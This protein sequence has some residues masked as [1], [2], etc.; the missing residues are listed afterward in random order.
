MA[1]NPRRTENSKDDRGTNVDDIGIMT[2]IQSG[3]GLI[4]GIIDESDIG[5]VS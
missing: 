2:T 1:G 5:T 3:H 4:R